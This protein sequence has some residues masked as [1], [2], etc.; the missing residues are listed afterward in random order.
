MS[1][2][3]GKGFRVRQDLHRPELASSPCSRRGGTAVEFLPAIDSLQ[4]STLCEF[5]LLFYWRVDWLVTYDPEDALFSRS[6]NGTRTEV[7]VSLE[8]GASLNSTG[9]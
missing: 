3:K 2:L 7:Q 4:R 9:S 1:W 6:L 5:Y 8:A